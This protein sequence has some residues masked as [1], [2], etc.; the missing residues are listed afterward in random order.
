[1]TKIQQLIERRI[2]STGGNI[3][4]RISSAI[5]LQPRP[6]YQSLSPLHPPP[7]IRFL[8]TS[9]PISLSSHRT[10]TPTG[11]LGK[12][13]LP[14][15][16]TCSIEI[17]TNFNLTNTI[18]EKCKCSH[19]M[20]FIPTE[21]VIKSKL[22]HDRHDA[23]NSNSNLNS[24]RIDY[25]KLFEINKTFKK[26]IS[27]SHQLKK[28]YHLW[29]QIV[30]PDF[31]VNQKP[32]QNE[33]QNE[34]S[35]EKSIEYMKDWS[36]LINRAKSVLTDDLKRAEYLMELHGTVDLSEES[37]SLDDTDLLMEIME[38][39]ELLEDAQTA[40]EVESIKKSNTQ[41]IQNV[42]DELDH[43]FMD[44]INLTNQQDSS[45]S[46]SSSQEQENLSESIKE[47]IIRSRYLNK[48]QDLISSTHVH[49]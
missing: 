34:Y 27:L 35:I 33:N 29:Q 42:L 36:V 26:T 21:F 19:C 7:H 40:Q 22:K 5:N 10:G 1:M 8:T 28:S 41:S 6:A 12:F 46:S 11:N 4:L 45:S 49:I 44:L 31:S 23:T 2:T 15:C 30:H 14:R 9:N 47:L 13:D 17:K 16:P 37:D 38:A 25:F 24:N 32:A 39:R 43:K 18:Q 20:A 3:S 48:I